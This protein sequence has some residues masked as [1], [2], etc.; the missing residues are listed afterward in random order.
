MW[1]NRLIWG[2]GWG[3]VLGE[4]ASGRAPNGLPLQ[5]GEAYAGK[6]WW[7][8]ERGLEGWVTAGAPGHRVS[9]GNISF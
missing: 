8:K 9:R 5:R 1:E 2:V 7:L 4:A 3:V 6:V